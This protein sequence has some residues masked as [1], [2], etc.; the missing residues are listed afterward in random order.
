MLA[1]ILMKSPS[2]VFNLFLWYVEVII[3]IEFEMVDESV[4]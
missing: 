1:D 4:M 3:H 2:L